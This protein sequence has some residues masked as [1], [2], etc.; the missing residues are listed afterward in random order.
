MHA[1]PSL[2]RSQPNQSCFLATGGSDAKAQWLGTHTSQPDKDHKSADNII[3]HLQSRAPIFSKGA[4][5]GLAVTC[6]D[7]RVAKPVL[8][9]FEVKIKEETNRKRV[10][11][12]VSIAYEDA[13]K[14]IQQVSIP[15]SKVT[16]NNLGKDHWLCSV[17]FDAFS[18]RH[19]WELIVGG[20]EH[21]LPGNNAFL[22]IEVSK[23]AVWSEGANGKRVPEELRYNLD[24]V[25]DA[26]KYSG[27][28]LPLL[29]K[30]LTGTLEP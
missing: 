10:Y 5:A 24:D 22:D 19:R 21:R 28:F 20:A 7:A 2:P 16:K 14:K 29:M 30:E 25:A 1:R 11:P 27:G 8:I 26:T 3:G 6:E 9:Q 15:W 23:V 18:K 17:P 13:E 12:S 4:P